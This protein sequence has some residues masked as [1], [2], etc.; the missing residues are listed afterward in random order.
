MLSVADAFAITQQ[1]RLQLPAET[2]SLA[3]AS[4]RVLREAVSADRNFP[5]FNR[6][7]MDGIAIRFTDYT[8]GQRTF[9]LAG[10][11]RAGEPQQTLDKANECLEIM[12]GAMLP[13]GVDTVIRY[14]DVTIDDCQA[15]LTI[16]TVQK[17]QHVHPQAIDRRAGDELLSIGMRLGPPELAVAASVGQTTLT[18]TALPRVALISTGDELVDIGDT[19]LPYQIRRSNTYLLQAG[20]ASLG[21]AATLHHIVDNE[22]ILEEQLATLLTQNDILILSGGVSAGK[23]DFV[24]S[25]MARLGVQKQFHKI[26]QRPGKPLWFGTTPDKAVFGLPG[27]PVSTVLCAYRYVMP[28]L[29]TSLGLAPA[30]IRYARL[31]A[32][33]VFAPAVTFFLPVR[34]TSEPDGRTLAH[35][36]PGSGSADFANLLAADAFMELPANRSEFGVDEAFQVWM[37]RSDR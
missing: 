6:V 18:V 20:L 3:D 25:V 2:V 14:E 1:H 28:Y 13:L 10:V 8:A 9:R 35:A 12:T 32:P 21:I 30:P 23:A 27:N 19:P 17:N 33:F 16:D 4:G 37:T 34:L 31:A 5:P 11:Q 22:A 24:P 26:E 36:L 15:T 29:R 7:A